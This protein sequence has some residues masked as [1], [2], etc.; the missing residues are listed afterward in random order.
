M[1][2]ETKRVSCFRSL[3][4]AGISAKLDQRFTV[5]DLKQMSAYDLIEK[6]GPVNIRFVHTKTVIDD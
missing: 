4:K 5:F 1:D 2:I 3:V 6:I